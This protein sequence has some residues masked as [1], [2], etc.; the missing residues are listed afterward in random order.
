M[1]QA[2]RCTSFSPGTETQIVLELQKMLHENNSY[3]RSF[4]YALEAATVPIFSVVIDTDKR[5]AGPH[6][7]HFNIP[8]CNEV[9]VVIYGQ[10]NNRRTIIL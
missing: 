3:I 4:K 2:E 8:T 1:N 5:P 7:S 10:Q 9:A 6:I